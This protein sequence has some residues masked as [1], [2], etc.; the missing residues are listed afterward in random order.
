MFKLGNFLTVNDILDIKEN[1]RLSFGLELVYSSNSSDNCLIYRNNH[2][3]S[4]A[5]IDTN[6][7]FIFNLCTHPNYRK[8]GLSKELIRMI[9]E[10]YNYKNNLKALTLNIENNEKGIIPKKIYTKLHWIIDKPNLLKTK[11]NMFYLPQT[12]ILKKSNKL[13]E[14]ELKKYNNYIN[15]NKDIQFYSILYG[16]ITYI[17]DKNCNKINFNSIKTKKNNLKKDK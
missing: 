17:I 13:I 6:S 1:T 11:I 9:I 15:K 4:C 3:V 8:Q 12:G 16:I 2:I 10:K 14:N 7:F 5:V